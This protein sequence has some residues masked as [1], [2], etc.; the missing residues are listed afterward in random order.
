MRRMHLV[1]LEDLPWF[2]GVLRDGG[3]SFLSFVLRVSGHAK[4]LTPVLADALR[5]TGSTHIIDLCTGGGGPLR[6]VTDELAALG[7]PVTATMTDFYPNTA[8]LQH[9]CD[10]TTLT[11]EGSPVDARAV[12]PHLVGFRTLFN[13]FHHFR[14]EEARKIL[15]DAAHARQPIG[16]FEVVSR[17]ALPLAGL[18]ML[19]ITVTL[20][21]PLWRPFRWPWVLWTWIIPVM[22]AFILWDGVVS[23]LRVYGEDELRE[24]VS[25]IDAPGYVWEIGTIKLGD[26][27]AHATYLIGREAT[28][29]GAA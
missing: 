22:Q 15:A 18:L 7:Q 6:I 20:T 3:T 10:G 23:W 13:A 8:S 26:A 16:V 2:P 12:P 25:T 4:M 1:E 9:M 19:P 28:D 24:L 27:P 29:A 5:K 21:M 11:F 14:P 17:E